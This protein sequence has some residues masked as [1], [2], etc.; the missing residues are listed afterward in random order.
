MSAAQPQ[1]LIRRKRR[2]TEPEFPDLVVE[3]STKKVRA[4]P[5]A[6]ATV[7]DTPHHGPSFANASH[8]FNG[9]NA[10]VNANAPALFF[11]VNDASNQR[12]YYRKVK[13]T[14]IESSDPSA[15]NAAASHD[16]IAHSSS[17]PALE[18]R[19]DSAMERGSAGAA[20]SVDE[21]VIFRTHAKKIVGN[22]AIIDIELPEDHSSSHITGDHAQRQDAQYVYDFYEVDESVDWREIDIQA[23]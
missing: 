17:S 5:T 18:V 6:T 9:S 21:L 19:E 23:L 7:T 3:T 22:A 4:L 12:R 14:A 16:S 20:E 10:T 11:K 2:V 15:E 13:T 1:I 8:S